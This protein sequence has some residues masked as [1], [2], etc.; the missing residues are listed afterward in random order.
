MAALRLHHECGLDSYE[1]CAPGEFARAWLGEHVPH[2]HDMAAFGHFTI[3]GRIS[4]SSPKYYSDL[5]A[6]SRK[7]REEHPPAERTAPR[8]AYHYPPPSAP[9]AC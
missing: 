9:P 3:T 8:N 5:V 7:H 1:P 4:R 6:Q 2:P